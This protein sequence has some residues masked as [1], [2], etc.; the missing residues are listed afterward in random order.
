VSYS[1]VANSFPMSAAPLLILAGVLGYITLHAAWLVAGARRQAPL[2][3]WAVGWCLAALAFV[4][5]RLYQ[6]T[7]DAEDVAL[8]AC[9]AQY[10]AAAAGSIFGVAIARSVAGPS[11]SSRQERLLLAAAAAVVVV[12]ALT[13]VAVVGPV[14]VRVDGL[15]SSYL[16]GT[17][18]PSLVLVVAGYLL[19]IRLI[20]RAVARAVYPAAARVLRICGAAFAVLA[21]NDVLLSAGI[22]RSIQLFEYG[23]CGFTLLGVYLLLRTMDA[24]VGSLESVVTVRSGELEAQGHTLARALDDVRAAESRYRQ[25]SDASLEGVLVHDGATVIDSNRAAEEIFGAPGTLIGRSLEAVFAREGAGLADALSG[26]ALGP[27][28]VVAVRPDGEGVP[29]EIIS[30]RDAWGTSDGVVVAVHDIR[31]KKRAQARLLLADRMASLSTVAAGMAH[32]INNP[33]TYVTLNLDIVAQELAEAPDPC[34]AP[35]VAEVRELL[36]EVRDGCARIGRIVSTMKALSRAESDE[37]S[38]VDLEKVLASAVSLADNQVRHRA[39]LVRTG[40]AAGRV[41]GSETGL[42]Q[43]FLN[44]LVNAA[45]SIEEGHATSNE[46]EITVSEGADAVLVEVRD[47]GKGIPEAIL[48]NIFDPFFTTKHD[49]GGTGLGLSVCH[50]IVASA[51]GDISVERRTRGSVFRVRLR[52]ATAE[53]AP[54]SVTQLRVEPRRR[55]RILVVDD[56][57]A[58]S[59]A[60]RRALRDHDT[61]TASTGHEAIELCRRERFDVVLCDLLMPEMTGME[62]FARLREIDP[63]AASR[64][65]FMSGGAFTPRARDF[66]ASVPNPHLT[67]PFDLFVVQELVQ[68]LLTRQRRSPSR[69]RELVRGL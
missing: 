36:A 58:T 20:G 41:V 48:P 66:L 46:V 34:P 22:L 13:P 3:P 25:L 51:G 64:A 2:P 38:A 37:P 23:L 43:V 67:K 45:Q 19:A 7:T 60:L 29:V 55:G 26:E 63:A 27:F 1:T 12:I 24:R 31:E 28:E 65:V 44:L 52:A 62:F 47:T 14:T 16:A 30:R 42:T 9:R 69:A 32:E 54:A 39:R 50:R 59:A 17:A 18:S 15:G 33:L 61:V 53:H 35:V 4:V 68:E 10:A 6:R 5:A 8:L 49:A 11:L 57:P 56:E 21:L 40:R